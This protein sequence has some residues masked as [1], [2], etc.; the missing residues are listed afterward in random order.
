MA[1]KE[2]RRERK[3]HRTKAENNAERNEFLKRNLKLAERRTES[4][5]LMKKTEANGKERQK[6]NPLFASTHVCTID[7]RNSIECQRKPL[8]KEEAAAKV[9]RR[10]TNRQLNI[11]SYTNV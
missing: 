9:E 2:P 5:E 4:S 6:E 11:E 10:K 1:H 7:T 8:I 3:R